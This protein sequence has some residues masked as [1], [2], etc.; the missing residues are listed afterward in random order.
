MK[1]GNERQIEMKE[2]NAF[3]WHI[4]VVGVKPGQRYGYR[5]SGPENPA[6]GERFNPS[7]LLIDPYARALTGQVDWSEPIFRY[8]FTGEAD[9]DL[10]SM[11]ATTRPACPRASSS[12]PPSIGST[13]GRPGHRCSDSII[14][15]VHVKGFTK[16]PSRRSRKSCAAPTPGWPHPAAIELSEEA[17]HH[18]GRADAG[19]R[20]SRRQAP[21]RQ[22]PAQLLGLQHHQLLRARTRATP[23]PATRASRWPS[24][25]AW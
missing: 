20:F 12:I 6:N 8:Q 21:G 16:L 3:V 1:T 5:V 14:Y 2:V 15:E 19:A 9:A 18:R 7:K 23:A 22:G 24:S 11:T 25:R 13:T 10:P 4:Y 17:R